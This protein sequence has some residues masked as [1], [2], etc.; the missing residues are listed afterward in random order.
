MKT[1]ADNA[2]RMWTLAIHVFAVK[3]TRALCGVDLYGLVD[4]KF[5]GLGRL[6]G[7][8]VQFVDVLYSLCKDE[9]D[10]LG[11]T[12]EDFGRSLAGDSLE[13]A[14]D[15][16][17]AELTDFFPDP[18]A[19]AGLRKVLEMGRGLTER[20]LAH[21]MQELDATDLDAAARTLIGSSGSLRASSGSTRTPSPSPSSP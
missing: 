17:L 19:R 8:P 2:G 12:D 9:A 16:F 10:K 1:F 15:A 18:R 13:R 3:R 14:T 11:I 5:E 4:E 20:V 21:A 6:L 7:D